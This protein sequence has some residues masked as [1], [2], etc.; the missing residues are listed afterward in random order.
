L[1]L[2]TAMLRSSAEFPTSYTD[3]MT[4]AGSG[5]R[6]FFHSPGANEHLSEAHLRPLLKVPARLFCLGYL[7]LLPRLDALAP[8]GTN[9]AARLLR[10][11]QAVGML[12]A[13]DLVSARNPRLCEQ[14][15]PCLPH[16]DILFLNEW[17]AG[18]LLNE[19]V[20]APIST[21]QAMKLAR[22]VHRLGVQGAV[23]LHF[24]EAVVAVVGENECLV[25]GSVQLPS[26]Q[27]QGTVG[28]GDALAAGVLLGRHQAMSWPE[29]LKLGV[30]AAAACLTSPTASDGLR[31]WK[32]CLEL[33][34]EF[35]FKPLAKLAA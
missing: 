10:D 16:L 28:A 6:T 20:N 5:R 31:P 1:K 21:E 26:Q 23:V 22:L 2:D 34:T 25:Q 12:T 30:C 18:Q 3:V 35:G 9:V 24:P 17:E 27:I 8:D 33:E 19:N 29:S 7:G 4:E 11:A 13:T 14:V 15:L 32:Q